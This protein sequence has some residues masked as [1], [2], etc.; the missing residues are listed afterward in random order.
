MRTMQMLS[1]TWWTYCCIPYYWSHTSLMLSHKNCLAFVLMY[2]TLKMTTVMN[3]MPAWSCQGK[4]VTLSVGKADHTLS[5][6]V[7]HTI[8]FCSSPQCLDRALLVVVLVVHHCLCLPLLPCCNSFFIHRFGAL[9]MVKQ[10]LRFKC[11]CCVKK[12]VDAAQLG[13]YQQQQQQQQEWC[14]WVVVLFFTATGFYC[15]SI[16]NLLLN[17]KESKLKILCILLGGGWGGGLNCLELV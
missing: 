12:I 1:K 13:T 3:L 9:W 7:I 6:N 10:L 5:A 17:Q 4:Y 2:T 14:V 15:A 16:R 8:F 11:T